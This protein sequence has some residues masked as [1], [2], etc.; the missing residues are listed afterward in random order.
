MYVNFKYLKLEGFLSIG[1]AEVVLNDRGMTRI[2]GINNYDEGSKSNGSG[3]SSLLEGI[4]WTLTEETARG[5]KDVINDTWKGWVLSE[6]IFDVDKVEYKLTRTR[7]HPD[8]GTNLKIEK[9][10][11]DISGNTYTKSKEILAQE[12]PFLDKDMI[13]SILLIS[14]GMPGRFS[15]MKAK[16]RK[17]RLEELS[18]STG[19]INE[20]QGR[21]NRKSK[22]LT[23]LITEDEKVL[24]TAR[25][26]IQIHRS[27]IETKKEYL[28][29]QQQVQSQGLTQQEYDKLHAELDQLQISSNEVSEAVQKLDEKLSIKV[30]ESNHLRN[31]LSQ[32]DS[33]I[34]Q[35]K[36]QIQHTENLV[37]SARN[38]VISLGQEL[39]LISHAQCYACKQ[40]I[41]DQNRVEQMKAD[42]TN[43]IKAEKQTMFDGDNAIKI[44]NQTILSTEKA[45]QGAQ[46]A[47]NLVDEEIKSITASKQELV[48]NANQIYAQMQPINER[49]KLGIK[50]DTSFDFI[51]SE[52]SQLE[53]DISELQKQID[54]V[55]ARLLVNKK[56]ADILNWLG[57]QSSRDF[58]SYLLKGVVDYLNHRLG[59][60]S[61]MLY[62]DKSKVY[63]KL[64]GNDLDLYYVTKPYEN[65]SGGERRR[66][67][68][69]MQLALRDLCRNE[70]DLVFNILALDEIFDNLDA[71][72]I[73]R[74]LEMIKVVS[75][76]VD[77]LLI[78]THSENL[79]MPYDSQILVEKTH[80]GFSRVVESY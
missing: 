60:Y 62:N 8:H 56:D 15:G 59:N 80:E 78:I 50:S 58:R 61:E 35:A 1:E 5:T 30:A 68:L 34:A 2:H 73:T 67:D 33:Q 57:R 38:N 41:V 45:K 71:E 75:S 37:N 40:D 63:L 4:I 52:I 3:K 20:L 77:S 9:N 25:S 43:K 74:V 14:Q 18:N 79:S 19:F 13:I 31:Q 29:R 10:G 32:F 72:G 53:L 49:L 23:K 36:M 54:E 7:K 65:L 26:S 51:E 17:E 69:C 11:E 39:Q 24:A 21:I 22:S 28:E 6:L 42:I 16:R 48:I 66:V 70:T 55:E 46:S 47:L 64:D 44:A 12:L 76:E 27:S